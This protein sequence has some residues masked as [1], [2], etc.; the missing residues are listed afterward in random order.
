MFLRVSA[1]LACVASLL[2]AFGMACGQQGPG[3]RCDRLSGTDNSG[4]GDCQAG[5]TCVKGTGASTSGYICCPPAGTA[6]APAECGGSTTPVTDA[7]AETGASDAA[8]GDADATATE[9]AASD[10]TASETSDAA[11]SDAADAD[12]AAAD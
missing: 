4:D 3:E 6:G 9:T 12:A 11:T 8:T 7:G 5:L 10:A 1:R 2:V